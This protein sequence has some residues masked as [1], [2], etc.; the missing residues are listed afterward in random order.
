MELNLQIRKL[1][2]QY[3][4]RRFLEELIDQYIDGTEDYEIKLVEDLQNT[5]DNYE[6]RYDP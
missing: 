1:L 6:G 5:L 2:S 3:G 4:T